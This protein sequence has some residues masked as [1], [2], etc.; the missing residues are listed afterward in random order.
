MRSS[1]L[2]DP[3][4]IFAFPCDTLRTNSDVTLAFSGIATAI[5]GTVSCS[6][7]FSA[8][9]KGASFICFLGKSFPRG[10]GG[11]ERVG[12]GGSG[13][14]D[15]VGV[16]EEEGV[17]GVVAEGVGGA[18]EGEAAGGGGIIGAGEGVGGFDCAS[19]AWSLY[20]LSFKVVFVLLFSL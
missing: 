12:T 1:V 17:D 4:L 20:L 19:S 18:A 11:A 16:E 15:E 5:S 9:G 2:N 10:G 6:G 3:S 14:V 13:G 8:A 7:S